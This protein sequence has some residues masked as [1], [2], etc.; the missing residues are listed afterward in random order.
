MKAPQDFLSDFHAELPLYEQGATLVAFLADYRLQ[1]KAADG[2]SASSAT[3][4]PGLPHRIEAL[5]VTMYEHGI[6]GEQ[7]VVLTRAWLNDLLSAGYT[8]EPPKTNA[9]KDE[10]GTTTPTASA[11]E[12]SGQGHVASVGNDNLNPSKEETNIAAEA[13]GA[14]DL[15]VTWGEE[16]FLSP[17]NSSDGGSA[18][19]LPAEAQGAAEP[20]GVDLIS[21]VAVPKEAGDKLE[22]QQQEDIGVDPKSQPV[23]EECKEMQVSLN[24]VPDQSWGK[25]DKVDR[26]RWESLGCNTALRLAADRSGPGEEGGDAGRG[27]TEA[28][29]NLQEQHL[30]QE[31]R[32]HD[33]QEEQQERREGQRTKGEAQEETA[34][35]PGE[36]RGSGERPFA[37]EVV[38][39]GKEEHQMQQRHQEPE[40]ELPGASMLIPATVGKPHAL[41]VIAVVSIRPDRR[42]AIRE[43]WLAWA[44]KRVVLRFFTE[45]PDKDQLDSQATATAL[46]QE[47]AAHGDLVV[48]D[49]DRGMNFALKLLSSMR[50][51]T[52]RYTFDYFLR[53]DDDYFIC[54]HRLLDELEAMQKTL[55]EITTKEGQAVHPSASPPMLYAGHRY[56]EQSATRIDEAYMLLSAALVQRVLS[57]PTLRCSA[58]AGISAGWWFTRGH[59]AN[60]DGDVHWVH[61]PRLDHFGNWWKP[62]N[63]G[64]ANHSAYASVCDKRMG[65][66]HAYPE[67]M[68]QLWAASKHASGLPQQ[69]EG[70]QTAG[71]GLAVLG[72]I[73]DAKCSHVRD[74]VSPKRFDNDHVQPCES[75]HA[76]GGVHC[77]A[78]KC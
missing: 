73:D 65:V 3:T 23:E 38:E 33:Q 71:S 10:G 59:K 70:K 75:Y 67:R 21:Q 39:I 5:A 32:E 16:K 2:A 34:V 9:V 52:D 30:Q 49:I 61:D 8:F 43:S 37:V 22:Q 51:L 60:R 56:C 19:P 46:A 4:L 28:N 14:K 63:K 42:A 50:Y 57:T 45:A 74:G 54:L 20:S 35:P 58:H 27:G 12:S 29:Q 26:Q 64:G 24:I 18:V 13:L 7:D 36:G 40:T 68:A 17:G 69:G 55:T 11:M 62:V 31:A 15:A 25:T 48:L 76:I 6:L 47:S 41:L 78:Q 44:D 1:L 77:G 53:L 66:H 72:Y